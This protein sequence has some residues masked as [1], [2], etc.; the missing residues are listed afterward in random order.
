MCYVGKVFLKIC[1]YSQDV[2]I[3]PTTLF[4]KKTQKCFPAKIAK[5]LRTPILK[6]I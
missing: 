3:H 5:F 1:Q 6:N 4:K 2:N